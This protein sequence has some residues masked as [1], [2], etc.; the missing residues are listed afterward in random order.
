MMTS[1]SLS[2]LFSGLAR[3]VEVPPLLERER[4]MRRDVPPFGVS[5]RVRTDFRP[6][7]FSSIEF[8]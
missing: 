5:K 8:F 4:E 1:R 6:D 2:L 3:G 7:K